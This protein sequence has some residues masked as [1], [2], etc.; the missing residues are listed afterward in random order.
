[1]STDH[2]DNPSE[3]PSPQRSG[4]ARLTA[5]L[6]LE[7]P[8]FEGPLDAFVPV[9]ERGPGDP[10]YLGGDLHAVHPDA[11]DRR[12]GREHDHSLD[13]ARISLS[14][15]ENEGLEAT[16]IEGIWCMCLEADLVDSGPYFTIIDSEARLRTWLLIPPA[17]LMVGIGHFWLPSVQPASGSPS[18]R[19]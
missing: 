16:A 8:L 2:D 15:Y 19:G 3:A 18:S 1:M 4:D 9:G 12:P 14:D 10:V 11:A 5:R 17:R 13:S 6:G 7:L